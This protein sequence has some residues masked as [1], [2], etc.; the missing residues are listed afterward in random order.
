MF[1]ETL[2]PTANRKS[3][4]R[5]A[6]DE[7]CRWERPECRRQLGRRDLRTAANREVVERGRS[8]DLTPEN[9]PTDSVAYR[10]SAGWSTEQVFGEANHRGGARG[11][12]R[13]TVTEVARK[14]GVSLQTMA[15]WRA[16]YGGMTVSEAREKRRLEDENAKLK[17]L[18]AQF[19]LE[20]ESLKVALG[21]K[22]VPVQEPG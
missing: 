10:R 8:D 16:R 3:I 17:K 22:W 19:A 12:G 21:K 14:N 7:H 5:Y 9:W 18:V 20:N 11:G 13:A 15:R 6:V 1:G 2:T 4:G